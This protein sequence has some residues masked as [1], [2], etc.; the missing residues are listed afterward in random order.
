MCAQVMNFASW[1]MIKLH[2]PVSI[3]YRLTST[4]GTIDARV[5]IFPQLHELCG[6]SLGPLQSTSSPARTILVISLSI[7]S[8]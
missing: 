5:G 7:R 1:F 4:G 3:K 8:I 2:L 6:A